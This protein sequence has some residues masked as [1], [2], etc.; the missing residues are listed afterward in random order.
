MAIRRTRLALVVAL[1][2][3]ALAPAG[4]AAQSGPD[5]PVLSQTKWVGSINLFTDPLFRTYFNQV[6]PENAGKWES[7]AGTT[8]TAAMR[9]G[10]L[11]TI[12]NFSQTNNLP[13][14]FHVLLWGNQQPAWM[15]N[16]PADE[17]LLE[18]K[19]W[20]Q[21]VATRYPNIKWLQ[22]VNEGTW[23][24][25]DGSTP[26]NAGA[27]FN[28]SGNYI[29]ALGNYNDTDGTGYDWILNAFRLAKQYFPN[30]KLMINDVVIT[31]MPDA[32][33]EYVKIINLLK[34]ENLVDAVGIQ[35][36]AFEFITPNPNV[37]SIPGRPYVPVT[38]PAIHKANLDRVVATGVPVQVTEL[39]LDGFAVGGVPGDE[40]QLEYYRKFVPVFW[41]SPGV[42][43]ITLWGWKA[44]SHWRNAQAAPIFNQNGSLKPAAHWLFNYVKKIP[45]VI[46]PA[47]TFAVTDANSANASSVGTVIA[48]DWASQINRLNLRTFKWRITDGSAAFSIDPGTGIVRIAD[49]R[50][51]DENTNY[52]LKVRVSDGFHESAEVDVAVA[53]GE[54]TSVVDGDVGAS[55]P[56]TLSLALGT[57]AGFGAF[58][59]GLAK[60]Y[61]SS[62][63]A[64]VISSA[65][66]AALS[67]ADP[68]S[69]APGRLVNGAFSLTQPVQ[70]A[71]SGAFAPVS[72]SPLTLHSYSGPVSNDALTIRFKQSIGASE[73][74]RTG[75]YSKTLTFTLSTTT[76]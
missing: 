20:F 55:V 61:E 15:A 43:G 2:G 16:L 70:A 7:A 65:G 30:T 11:D 36:H 58:T 71:V 26:K 5:F 76:P 17:Q 59:P 64:T 45:P 29:K 4:A 8:R 12:Y 1:A 13:F 54:L 27:N 44:P 62:T 40:K 53:T 56:A 10:N 66:D 24:P 9:W 18:I 19:K 25:P 69:T 22:V 37:P 73:P 46:R 28:S 23:D 14:N 49:Q 3:A 41:E 75:A 21:A 63:A 32:T 67:V 35:A 48:D 39:D 74:L 57:N 33:T 38:D 51:L 34:R 31:G 47:Q 42:E 6:T 60:D 68:S 52:T 72:G 50:Q